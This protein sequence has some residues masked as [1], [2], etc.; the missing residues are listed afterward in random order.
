MKY[1]ILFCLLFGYIN[2]FES[3]L[4]LELDDGSICVGPQATSIYVLK[5]CDDFGG[6]IIHRCCRSD[7]N[8]TLV[9]I[10]LMDANLTAIPNFSEHTNL[11]LSVID[12]RSN[13][14]IVSSH[15]DDFLTLAFLDILI[16]PPTIE[17]PGGERIW[18]NRTT[19][20]DPPGNLCQT[21][22]SFCANSTDLCTEKGSV[23]T[24]NGPY[25]F[26]C[27]CKPGYHGYKCLRNGNFPS[28]IFY[29]LTA[30]VTVLASIMLY[31]TQRRH[32]KK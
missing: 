28:G 7:D 21:Q 31:W 13:P 2:C 1:F 5:F 25:H 30:A 9:A 23:C 19:V 24:A 10:D 6:T 15:D 16:L 17:C 32:V 29:G 20:K 4:E 14:D 22:K 12:L 18:E 8:K 3:E 26:L 11:N 27:S